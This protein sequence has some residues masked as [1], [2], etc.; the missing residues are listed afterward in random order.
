MTGLPFCNPLMR[1]TRVSEGVDSIETT[2]RG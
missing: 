2:K 1:F